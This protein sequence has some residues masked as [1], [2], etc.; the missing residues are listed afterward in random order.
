[1]IT[2][3]VRQ[4]MEAKGLTVREVVERTGLAKETI[5][6]ARGQMIGRCT[7]DTLATIAGALGCR[8]KDLFEEE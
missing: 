5:N 1:M 6:R 2:S 3:R 4:A 7:L 8:V